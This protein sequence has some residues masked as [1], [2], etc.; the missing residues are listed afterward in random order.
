MQIYVDGGLD[1][2]LTGP[3]GA[4]TAPPNLRVG[5]LETG[6][7]GGF[8]LGNVSDVAMYDRVLTANQVATLYRAASGLFYGITMTSVWNGSSLMLSWPGNGRLLE[9]TNLLGPWTT[10]GAGSPVTVVPS[11]PG[12]FYR[13]QLQ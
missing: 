4:R 9:S 12:R 1:A 3:V 11:Q 10:N 2:S 8:L 13:V 6:A 5:S 7:S